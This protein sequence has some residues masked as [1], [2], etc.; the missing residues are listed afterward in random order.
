MI[1][2][3]GYVAL[4]V[5][6]FIL[7]RILEA[8]SNGARRSCLENWRSCSWLLIKA[9]GASCSSTLQPATGGLGLSLGDEADLNGWGIN[10]SVCVDLGFLV[11]SSSLTGDRLTIAIGKT[12]LVNPMKPFVSA[13]MVH[14]TFL[15]LK[16]L[17]GWFR[18]TINSGQSSR[19]FPQFY[20][21]GV[22]RG[23][24][25]IAAVRMRNQRRHG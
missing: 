6:A 7:S 24:W 11:G 1:N 20:C 15:S 23:P 13:S 2:C 8:R 19:E 18:M 21:P 16:T 12:A 5:T 9:Q 22:M 3:F 17:K 25:P 10:D 4:S 14:P